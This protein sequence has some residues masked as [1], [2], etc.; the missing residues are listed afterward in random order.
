M[1]PF[2]PV[3]PPQAQNQQPRQLLPHPEA[4]K[5][6]LLGGSLPSALQAPLVTPQQRMEILK[7]PETQVLIQSMFLTQSITAEINIF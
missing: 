6:L 7:R 2:G 5:K 3:P 4:L 1:F